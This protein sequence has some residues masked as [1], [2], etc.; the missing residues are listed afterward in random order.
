MRAIV[1]GLLALASILIV[2]PAGHTRE[3]QP[4]AWALPIATQATID[5]AAADTLAQTGAPSAS[6][7][8]VKDGRIAYEH[9]YGSARLE[10]VLQATP[11]M[12]YSIGSISK[13]FTATAMLLL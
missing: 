1:N 13:Q 12:R 5:K 2:A 10:P 3:A 4:Q 7:A 11:A 8:V 9:A 6:I